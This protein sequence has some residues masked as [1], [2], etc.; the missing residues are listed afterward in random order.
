[1][2]QWSIRRKRIILAIIVSALIILVGIPSFLIFYRAPTCFDGKLNGSETGVD[3]GGSCQLLC[4]AESLPIISRGDPQV[5]R[6]SP[7]RFSVVALLE[8]PNADGEILSAEYTIKIYGPSQTTPLATIDGE[9]FI[10]KGSVFAIFEGPINISGEVVPTRAVLEWKEESF[11]WQKNEVPLPNIRVVGHE[12]SGEDGAPRINALIENTTLDNINNI[13]IVALVSD[14]TGNI[15]GAARTF[16]ESIPPR[17][18]S[19]AVFTWSE[20]F[21]KSVVDVNILIRVLPGGESI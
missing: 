12:L 14:E 1:M 10:P 9:I 16:L 5:L 21:E 8:N 13:D 3:C 7:G 18:T 11:S 19:P 15:F 6:V 17:G 20:P 4:S 2:N